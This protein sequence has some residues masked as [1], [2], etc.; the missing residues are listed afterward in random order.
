MSQF[1]RRV[2]GLSALSVLSAAVFAGLGVVEQ[3]RAGTA[4]GNIGVYSKYVL[5]GITNDTENDGTTVQGGFDY[6]ADNGFFVGYWGSNL[7]YTYYAGTPPAVT[8]KTGFENDFYAGYGFK[9]GSLSFTVGATQYYYVEVDDSNLFEPFATVAMGPVT[10]GVKYLAQDGVWGNKG[11]MYWTFA[12]GTDLPKGFKLAGT[13]GY[14]MYEKN[15]N[16]ELCGGPAG[17]GATKTG[18]AFRHLDLTLS[19][20]IG[21]TGADMMVTYVIGGENRGKVDQENAFVFGI[22]Y[23]FDL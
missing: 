3:A 17:C 7:D 4:T 14:Y 20:P 23:P 15:D 19:H 22:K 13:L 21:K 10:V 16:A 8:T 11:D 6:A 9:A 5:R 18:S 12:A 2:S 1:K